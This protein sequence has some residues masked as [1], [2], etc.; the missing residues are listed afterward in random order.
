MMIAQGILSLADLLVKL[1]DMSSVETGADEAG[2]RIR[3]A[4]AYEK[5]AVVQWVHE[6][7]GAAWASECDVA[8]SNRPISCFLA[9]RS[10]DIVGFACYDSACRGF[11][12]PIGVDRAARGQRIGRRLLIHTLRAMRAAGYGYA[13]IGAAGSADFYTKAVGAIEI[14]GSTPGIYRDRLNG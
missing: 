1:Y 7:F 10:G 9:T 14:P 6:R 11:F 2:L 12:G 5:Q 13:V 4:M 8:F 3:A